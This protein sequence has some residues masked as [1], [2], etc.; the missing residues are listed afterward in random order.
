ML[1]QS[2]KIKNNPSLS[3]RTKSQIFSSSRN[4]TATIAAQLTKWSLLHAYSRTNAAPRCAS[5]N[6]NFI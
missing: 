4:K 1:A 2:R 5:T 3:R 6:K